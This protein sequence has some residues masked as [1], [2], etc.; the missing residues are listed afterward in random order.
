MSGKPGVGG[1]SFA[2]PKCGH[3]YSGVTDTR[4]IAGIQAT[5]R[6]RRCLGC[7]LR[8]TTRETADWKEPA[9][10]PTLPEAIEICQALLRDCMVH[11]EV[12]AA[13]AVL[14]ATCNQILGPRQ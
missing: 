9:A 13:V 1:G 8:F 11:P 12:A 4:P 5:R 14:I 7:G 2:C 6:R 10:A 3:P